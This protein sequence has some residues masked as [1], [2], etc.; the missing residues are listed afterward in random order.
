M[1]KRGEIMTRDIEEKPS[2]KLSIGMT[3]SLLGSSVDY[4]S[5]GRDCTHDKARMLVTT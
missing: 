2:K 5:L 3:F 4:P 1:K